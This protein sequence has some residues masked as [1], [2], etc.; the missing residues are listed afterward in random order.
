MLSGKDII[1]FF[2]CVGEKVPL[3]TTYDELDWESYAPNEFYTNL[4]YNPLVILY[5]GYSNGEFTPHVG[6]W[7]CLFCDCKKEINFFDS[8]GR[9]PDTMYSM[10]SDPSKQCYKKLIHY[11]YF[12]S[13][14]LN[15]PINYN[16]KKFQKL[17]NSCGKWVCVRLYLKDKTADE[18]IERIKETTADHNTSTIT[19]I[20][21]LLKG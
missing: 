14:T 5:P 2:E 6:H 17:E 8:F 18:F 20:Y 16:D 15:I 10:L 1:R 19:K 21:N 13:C 3:L 12:V 11:L 7:T 9:I 4:I